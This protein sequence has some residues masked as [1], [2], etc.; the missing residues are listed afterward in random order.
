MQLV[1]KRNANRNPATVNTTPKSIIYQLYDTS[2]R[3]YVTYQSYKLF[4][5]SGNLYFDSVYLEIDNIYYPDNKIIF[6]HSMYNSNNWLLNS[7]TTNFDSSQVSIIRL[8]NGRIAQID[9][10]Y[11]LPQMERMYQKKIHI[12]GIAN[13]IWNTNFGLKYMIAYWCKEMLV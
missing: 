12:L 11:N 3:N 5:D 8:N 10:S 2:I 7:N 4:R 13:F 6:N 9:L 1:V